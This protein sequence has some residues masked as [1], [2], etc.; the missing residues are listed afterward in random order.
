MTKSELLELIVNGEN[1]G[2]EFKLDQIRPVQLAKEFVAFANFQGGSVLLGVRDDGTVAGIRRK[3]LEHWLM[4]TVFGRYVHPAI[5]P[6][7]EE[8]QIDEQRRVAIIS[9]NQGTTKPYVVRD[10]GR[11]TV[12]IR[13][14]STSRAATREQQVRLFTIGGMFHTELLPVSGS[15][16]ADFSI[17]RLRNYVTSILGD[18]T[19][20]VDD[21][22]CSRLCSLGFMVER[23]QFPAV[24]TLAGVLLFGHSPR[25][26]LPQ[27]GI[28]WMA[29]AG[30]DKSYK[31]LDDRVLDGPLVIIRKYTSARDGT[32]V[33]KGILDGLIDAMRPFISVDSETVDV[34]MRRER[35][36]MYP[37]EAIREA[38]VN[39][40][41]HRDWT[42]YED[43]EVVSYDD[44]LEI[45]SPGALLN[46]MTVGK[47]MAGQ[48]SPRNSLLVSILRDYG[49]VDARG[50]GVRNKIIPLLREHNDTEP[51]FDATE[52]YLK[53]VMYRRPL[54]ET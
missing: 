6:F 9:V 37:L 20:P 16:L 47:M 17:D 24:G 48:R 45:Q 1:S 25:R 32:I 26:L 38:V 33:E 51:E 18:P 2:V 46:S 34:S 7:Y 4:D 53:V 14:G 52:D 36:W 11:E 12:Y 22:W 30:K 28:R 15:Q 42:R 21:E 29:F 10:Q 27:T 49:Y 23:E 54:H 41:A 19:V 39:A 43:I 3:N 13:V 31:A 5:I 40:V 44:R 50:M 8:V 35:I